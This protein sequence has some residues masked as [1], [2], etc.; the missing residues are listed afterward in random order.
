MYRATV[1]RDG[2]NTKVVENIPL[3]V[4]EQLRLDFALKV[5][6]IAVQLAVEA[7]AAALGTENPTLGELITDRQV[8]ELPLN[9]RTETHAIDSITVPK[10]V[11]QHRVPRECPHQLRR[12][13]HET[14]MLISLH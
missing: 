9:G 10:Y 3:R 2:F 11:A 7:N 14:R 6:Q 8:V 12:L 5:G 4:R 1:T 13:S